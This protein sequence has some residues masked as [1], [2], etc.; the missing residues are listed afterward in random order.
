M[1]GQDLPRLEIP[2]LKQVYV[3]CDQVL[4]EE[5]TYAQHNTK[6]SATRLRKALMSLSKSAKAAR[7]KLLPPK[8]TEDTQEVPAVT[9]E[10][11]E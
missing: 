5:L 6:A 1:T 2:E 3:L 8:E 7:Q 4:K 9:E 10:P 11:K